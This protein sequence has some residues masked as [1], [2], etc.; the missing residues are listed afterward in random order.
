MSK[1]PVALGH[2]GLLSY[3]NPN[4]RQSREWEGLMDI[5]ELIV[6]TFEGYW[7]RFERVLEGLTSEELAW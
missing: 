2:L 3:G 7:D 6:G 1:F 4:T 5:K